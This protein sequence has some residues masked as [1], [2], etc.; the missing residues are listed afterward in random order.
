MANSSFT[1]SV[2]GYA[3]GTQ[4]GLVSTV[5]Q[6]FAGKKTLDGGAL[7]KGDTSGVAVPSGYVGD[8]ISGT[9]ISNTA[10][11]SGTILNIGNIILNKGLYLINC[12]SYVLLGGTTVP[13]IFRRGI[14]TANNTLVAP[15]FS[16]GIDNLV[17][18]DQAGLFTQIRLISSDS[19]TLYFNSQVFF[20]TSSATHSQAKSLLQALR[21]G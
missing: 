11:S 15:G 21:I 18:A 5:A 7:I 12:L 3:S 17:G 1:G 16:T 20:T 14:S 13:Q 9:L 6:T 10:Y 2:A 19:T 8:I 4:P